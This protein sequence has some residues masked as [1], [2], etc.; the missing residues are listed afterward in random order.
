[1]AALLLLPRPQ[2]SINLTTMWY[3]P[4]LPVKVVLLIMWLA[5]EMRNRGL[6][7]ILI[8]RK[9]FSLFL[10]SMQY[11]S[12]GDNTDRSADYTTHRARTTPSTCVGQRVK[13]LIAE[14]IDV[15]LFG[16]I[17]DVVFVLLFYAVD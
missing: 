3:S 17:C 7:N 11:Q 6:K 5:V 1:M 2:L 8:Q 13:R 12:R 14:F 9:S 4:L 16:F 15:Y 10:L